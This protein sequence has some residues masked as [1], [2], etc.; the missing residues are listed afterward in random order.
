MKSETQQDPY[1]PPAAST[2]PSGGPPRAQPVSAGNAVLWLSEAWTLFRASPALLILL[3]LVQL[4]IMAAANLVPLA[5][6]LLMPGLMAGFLLGIAGLD[7]G[8]PLALET[9]IAGF[10]SHP[11]PLLVL[12]A[13]LLLLGLLAV[14]V[15]G[16]LLAVAFTA[17]A[18]DS[19][20]G[21]M[22]GTLLILPVLVGAFLLLVLAMWWAPGLVVLHHLAPGVALRLALRGIT[23]NL[24][25]V[26]VYGL[27]L[28]LLY[29]LV[30]ITAGL[31]A[32]V[33]GPL[34]IITAYTSYR[35]IFQHPA[36]TDQNR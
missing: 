7:H 19:G 21:L 33:V 31:A 30:V 29:L 27:I 13:L 10:K 8:R 24:L 3:W 28:L 18:S 12:G 26:L 23:L 14:M 1:H 36:T 25:P 4:L 22:L 15:G 32:L 6:T 35:D 11:G 9:L 17:M 34:V 16:T 2:G 5:G 20:A